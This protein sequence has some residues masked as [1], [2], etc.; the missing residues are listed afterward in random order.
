[1]LLSQL[2]WEL[3]IDPGFS[4]MDVTGDQDKSSFGGVL[5]AKA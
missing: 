5:V 3:M 1:M 2:R 4:N